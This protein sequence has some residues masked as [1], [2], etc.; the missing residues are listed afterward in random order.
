MHLLD[1][2]EAYKEKA[3]QQLHKDAKSYI[4]Q[5]LEATSHKT[6]AVRPPLTHLKDHP[7]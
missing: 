7:N 1:A 4:K 2:D 5:I 6:A 3:W